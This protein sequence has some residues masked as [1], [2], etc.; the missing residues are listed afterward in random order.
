VEKQE[1]IRNDAKSAFW[2]YA[3][4]LISQLHLGSEARG[5]LNDFNNARKTDKFRSHGQD[6]GEAIKAEILARQGVQQSREVTL[7]SLKLAADALDQD[8]IQKSRELQLIKG[9]LA[10]WG[11]SEDAYQE[12]QNQLS[13]IDASIKTINESIT[14]LSGYITTSLQYSMPRQSTKPAWMRSQPSIFASSAFS[15]LKL[16]TMLLFLSAR[17]RM[18]WKLCLS[19]SAMWI[20]PLR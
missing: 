14:N 7:A 13:G 19:R 16:G 18:N 15:E 6:V 5:A 8:A 1:K 9:Q 2:A 4:L 3:N 17:R 10:A 11:H 12:R 20:R